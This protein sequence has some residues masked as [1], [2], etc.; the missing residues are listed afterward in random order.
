MVRLQFLKFFLLYFRMS[1]SKTKF[2]KDWLKKL[3]TNKQYISEWC[4]SSSNYEF[5][6]KLCKYTGSCTGGL[7]HLQSHAKSGKHV[8][9]AKELV[10]QKRLMFHAQE[11]SSSSDVSRK[12]NQADRITKAEILWTLKSV[13]S[14]F[15]FSSCDNISELFSEMFETC[16]VAKGLQLCRSKLSYSISHG[17]G[18]FFQ[19]ELCRDI[20]NSGAPYGICFDETTSVQVVKQL[21]IYVRFYDV[22][23]HQV[24]VRYLTSL[25]LGHATA[26]IVSDGLIKTL[27]ERQLPLS[28]M[29]FLSSDG[30]NVNKS[31]WEKVN[32]VV[33]ETSASPGLLPLGFCNLHAVHNAFRKGLSDVD[34]WFVEEF[35]HDV[36]HWFKYSAPRREDYQH[37]QEM[38]DLESKTF[39]R[40]VESRWTT[41]SIVLKVYIEQ[42]PALKHYFESVTDSNSIKSPRF[43]R[44]SRFLK[45]KWSLV[46]MRFLRSI[47]QL[48]NEFLV[49]FQ[50]RKPLIHAVYSSLKEL[51][52]KLLQRFIKQEVLR[53]LTDFNDLDLD[54]EDNYRPS[55]SIIHQS[56]ENPTSLFIIFNETERERFA[57][58]VLGF[59]KT[60]VKYL[61]K[62]LPL[63]NE[64][65]YDV[66][67]LHPD[68]SYWPS[69]PLLS[70]C[71]LSLMI[72]HLI[73]PS[74]ADSLKDEWSIYASEM[75]VLPHDTHDLDEH[76]H[77][78][79]E[80]KNSL[81]HTKFPL[82]SKFAKCLIIL[83]HGNA[84]P[85][86]G[87][88]E[89]KHILTDERSVL[90]HDSIIGL[91]TVKNVLDV[92]DGDPLKVLITTPMIQQFRDA[93]RIYRSSLEEEK[94]KKA[95]AEQS[96]Q[97]NEQRKRKIVELESLER[98]KRQLTIQLKQVHKTLEEANSR[99]QLA[100]RCS[101]WVEVSTASAMIDSSNRLVKEI[102]EKVNSLDNEILSKKKR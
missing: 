31:I 68:S 84:D 14:N 95:I 15:S 41:L 12:W 61:L 45:S 94:R 50:T 58:D 2:N 62:K 79:Q 66:Q 49:V 13:K 46:Y 101:D 43:K 89:N 42:L 18:P 37:V 25:F 100:V 20:R 33:K 97:M 32:S 86:R 74:E 59:Y 90:S 83:T 29:L 91:R 35:V 21:D 70:L 44:I 56:E 19:S 54:C 5:H 27:R 36:F 64:V 65:Y 23:R 98:E 75:T 63:N 30:P 22:L 77:R 8:N 6:C 52:F 24:T 87:F 51:L 81:G 76:W 16:E 93:S 85:E 26:Q 1:K 73:S 71:R 47:G 55:V 67:L 7:S 17:L 3:D 34:H 82:L 39:A 69:N 57:A 92:N 28:L 9:L 72:K 99:L 78:V 38:L 80:M 4:T 96:K 102:D 53:N 60:I 10:G 88:S 40:Y 11:C 48:L